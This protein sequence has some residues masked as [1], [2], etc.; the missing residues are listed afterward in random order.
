VAAVH[1]LGEIS[2]QGCRASFEERFTVERM[3]RNYVSV[4][5]RLIGERPRPR[6]AL[7]V[8]EPNVADS[9]PTPLHV[10]SQGP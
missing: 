3:A 2:R 7:A 4:Y 9:T 1:R 8:G 5:E 10:E 6:M